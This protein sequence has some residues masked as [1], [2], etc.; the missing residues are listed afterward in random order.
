MGTKF[1]DKNVNEAIM[2]GY[3]LE[4]VENSE[5]KREKDSKQDFL[6]YVFMGYLFQDGI[7]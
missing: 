3:S 2:S 7:Y 1:A 5:G 6:L 4:V